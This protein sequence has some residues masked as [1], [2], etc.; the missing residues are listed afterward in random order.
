MCL[1]FK[2]FKGYNEHLKNKIDEIAQK[3]DNT[4]K[5]LRSLNSLYANAFLRTIV[6]HVGILTKMDDIK[7]QINAVNRS[8]TLCQKLYSNA[9]EKLLDNRAKLCNMQIIG[10][11]D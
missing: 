2:E 9:C 8:V 3:I 11:K 4:T 5:R 10:K 6:R 1:S 7:C